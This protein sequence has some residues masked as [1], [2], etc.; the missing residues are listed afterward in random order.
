MSADKKWMIKIGSIYLL[1]DRRAF[2]DRPRRE[3]QYESPRLEYSCM[4][5]STQ[6]T[7]TTVSHTLNSLMVI[8]HLF[9]GLDDTTD[10]ITA[11]T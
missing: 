8:M 11:E 3:Q 6:Q 1:N 5:R 10:F 2:K 9:Q 7:I 4:A